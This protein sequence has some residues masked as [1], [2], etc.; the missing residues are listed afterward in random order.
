[1]GWTQEVPTVD[2]AAIVP[3]AITG[4]SDI[5]I[6]VIAVDHASQRQI[7]VPAAVVLNTV[8]G[9]PVAMDIGIT[10]AD[11]RF[12]GVLP[13]PGMS[14]GSYEIEV[15]VGGAGPAL[16]STVKLIEKS[17]ILLETDKPIYKPGQTIHGRLL[18][19]D[20]QLKPL[21]GDAVIEISDGKGMKV[22]RKELSAHALGVAHFDL[23]LATELNLGTW[24]IS[25][26]AE[27]ASGQV[28]VRVEEYVLPRFDIDLHTSKDYYLVSE[29]VLGSVD[30][31]YFF[32]KPVDGI[33]EIT[34]SR[35]VGVW[36]PYARFT[37]P[38]TMGQAEFELPAVEYVSGTPSE[39]GS[40]SVQL[41]VS[42]SDTS[43]HR[44]E[45]SELIPMV[46]SL[47]RHQIIPLSRNLV[48]ESPFELALVAE[49]PVGDPVSVQGRL[50]LQYILNDDSDAQ[51]V[52]RVP[53]FEGVSTIHLDIPE[54]IKRVEI[55]SL[56]WS[57]QAETDASLTLYC[58]D[59]ATDSFVHL[60]SRGSSSLQVGQSA[61]I[62]VIQAHDR[63]VYYDVFA[64][65][66]TLYSDVVVDDLIE[67][68]ITPAMMPAVK[69]V[70][71][72][73]NPNN[74]IAADSVTLEVEMHHDLSVL[75]TAFDANEA[76][77]GGSVQVQIQAETEALVGIAVV[78][79]SV[80]ALN[81][82][83]LNMQEVMEE[84]EA[85]YMRPQQESHATYPKPISAAQ[86][87]DRAGCRLLTNDEAFRTDN[88]A[89]RG[90]GGG[91]S[92]RGGGGSPSIPNITPNDTD[93]LAEVGY[94]RQ[95]FPE[96]W[97]WIPDLLTDAAG[98]AELDLTVPDSITTWRLHAVSTSAQGLGISESELLVFQEFFGEPDLPYE[99]TQGE[100]FPVRIQI[101]NYLPVDQIVHVTLTEASWFELFDPGTQ[102]VL[103][104]ANSV[105]LASFEIE[106]TELGRH[107]VEVTL[108]SPL[109]ADAVR[110]PLKVEPPGTM[111]EIVT[112]DMLKAGQTVALDPLLPADA[113]DGSG[114]RLLHV[115]SSPAA[116]S[117]SGLDNLLH[118]PYGCGEQNM[119]FFAPDVEVLRYL[120]ATGQLTP[121]IRAK[122]EHFISTGYQRELTYRHDD[123]SFS[124][125]GQRDPSGSL[126]LT[127]FVL[128]TF[129]AARDVQTI[130]ERVLRHACRW[131]EE[132]QLESGAWE[133]V[134]F[135]HHGDMRGGVSGNLTLTAYVLNALADYGAASSTS[136]Q[137]GMD[138]L[139]EHWSAAQDSP[140]ALAIAC[141]ASQRLGQVDLADALMQRLDTL[142]VHDDQGLHWEP[143][144]IE[145]AAYVALCMAER[146]DNRLG[147]V[148]TWLSLQQNS[149][150]GYRSTQD[151]VMALKALMKSATQ[152]CEHMELT[153]RQSD[154]TVLGQLKLDES[155]AD[156]VQTLILDTD[157]P[158][159]LSASG[160]GR[161]RYQWVKR[162]HVL[163]QDECVTNN[164]ALEVRYSA[165]HVEVDDRVDVD[166]TV[167]YLGALSS[168]GMM[169]V[170]VGVPTGFAP[171][172]AS[173]DALLE[174]EVV[175]RIE[176]AGRKLIFY[177]DHLAPDETRQF[178]FQV[179]A[180]WPVR[181][182][183]PD[184]YTYLYYEPEIRAETAGSEI[185]VEDP[186]AQE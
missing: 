102:Q 45:T 20:E 55:N 176:K 151:T 28:D 36:E 86:Q 104:P 112:N 159:F 81:E 91:G 10:D 141:L 61:L 53:T 179:V 48:P 149:L 147:E 173:L 38:L 64:N 80:Y 129:S 71:Y 96:T 51:E 11:G 29:P 35:Y 135:L 170:D 140:Y 158:L 124:A 18:L 3:K 83:R 99:V 59:A 65:G 50:R 139:R 37:T 134:G 105:G 169:I 77:P 122:A 15:K 143:H 100:R 121:E 114:K 150:G 113:L 54:A 174:D 62:D 44:E 128:G 98:Y 115:T 119:I 4:D 34:A 154:G 157:Q 106:P 138:Y 172:Q 16:A 142:A 73:I 178:S 79:E 87:F 76:L 116:Q 155:N 103:V 182:V 136:L 47:I 171:L 13:V 42:V 137:K 84:L 167:R 40:A 33:V 90:R 180:R 130:D 69:V 133:P 117:I 123:G 39:G 185:V 5:K 120:D 160:A 108:R 67:I 127:A 144:A 25:A 125:F 22:F 32:G 58:H 41:E 93:D 17:M 92:G 23:D 78:D 43:E 60:R 82:G 19:L 181:A 7:S 88:G 52:I 162:F 2:A 183:I 156:L 97:V 46:D 165:D 75:R 110:K 107:I 153:V 101:F 31:R 49:T 126:W 161:V 14:P 56:V 131:I 63:T 166:V 68:S 72:V 177:L 94:V 95:F 186:Q 145:T 1:V 30:A 132:H 111:R 184:S 70:A 9:M 66:H 57:D 163:L 74:E 24:R 168:T 164:L 152:T 27:S 6:P 85:F 26:Q 148:I 109:R 146:Y 175:S 118:L 8:T 12:V 89:S 21:A